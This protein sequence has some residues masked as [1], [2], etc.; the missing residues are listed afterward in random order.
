MQSVWEL[1]AAALTV[2][3][4]PSCRTMDDFRSLMAEQE[5]NAKMCQA[6]APEI[7]DRIRAEALK[8]K[9]ELESGK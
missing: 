7:A 9:S 8:R 4:L 5:E 6:E 2:I 1:Y 3:A